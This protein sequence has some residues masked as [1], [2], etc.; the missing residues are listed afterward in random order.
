MDAGVAA[1]TSAMF[2]SAPGVEAG[3]NVRRSLR[4]AI[5]STWF[6]SAPGDRGRE[7]RRGGADATSPAMFQSA[8]GVEAGRNGDRRHAGAMRAAI[9]SIRSR[10]R[11]REKRERSP[12]HGIGQV[13]IRSRRRGREK[14]RP[15]PSV[16]DQ[17]RFNPLPASR[18]GERSVRP[19]RRHRASFNPLPASRPGETV[20]GL[21]TTAVAMRFNPLPA[22]RPGE[23]SVQV[24]RAAA[25]TEL[26]QSAPGID[27]GRN[28][29]PAMDHAD[30]R[31][32]IRSRHR[33]REKHGGYRRPTAKEF[34]SAPGIEAGRNRSARRSRQDR[35][36]NPLPA[37]RPGETNLSKPLRNQVVA[38]PFARSLRIPTGNARK[39]SASLRRTLMLSSSSHC[40]EHSGFEPVSL[41]S[42]KSRHPPGLRQLAA[43]PSLPGTLHHDARFSIFRIRPE[44]RTVNCLPSE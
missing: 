13:S 28:S 42:R 17:W 31:V 6:Q 35:G 26:F 14:R 33:C 2:Q 3:R 37:S 30:R 15:A 29:S 39:I 34:Q 25:R 32:S 10:R 4:R 9:V 1:P 21:P 41:G 24:R 19:Q 16:R 36:F 44:N 23:T 40:R 18:P 5:G 8:P 22:S 20:D 38:P 43:H 12:H 11:G 27:A 7:K